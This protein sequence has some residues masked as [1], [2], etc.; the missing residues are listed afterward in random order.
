M[1][2]EEFDKKWNKIYKDRVNQDHN[3]PSPETRERLSVLETNVS[4]FMDILKQSIQDN[5]EAHESLVD[6]VKGIENKLDSALEK[7]ADKVE[8]D[9]IRGIIQWVSYTIIGGVIL[10]LLA[11]VL[12]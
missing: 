9:R 4:N 3:E 5:K 2:N 8:V 11:L 12:K 10:A 7:K 6:M 1:T